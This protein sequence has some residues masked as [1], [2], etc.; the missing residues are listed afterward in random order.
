MID[1]SSTGVQ[2]MGTSH[3]FCIQPVVRKVP[4]IPRVSGVAA[5]AY[6]PRKQ[7]VYPLTLGMLAE[8]PPPKRRRNSIEILSKF[9]RSSIEILSKFYRNSIEILST[10]GRRGTVTADPHTIAL[11]TSNSRPAVTCLTHV[12]GL[13]IY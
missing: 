3:L 13:S 11:P 6:K 8:S 2:Y 10:Y 12:M 4:S 1:R 9:Y 5:S 7:S